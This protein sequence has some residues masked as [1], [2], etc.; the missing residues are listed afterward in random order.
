MAFEGTLQD[1]SL[2]DVCR[3]MGTGRK[4]GCLSITDRSSFGYIYFR[5]GRVVHA[6]MLNRP[7]RLGEM[8]VR[9]R[10]VSREDLAGA[11]RGQSQGSSKRLG[12]LLLEQ[13]VIDQETLK[14]YVEQQVEEAVHHLFT[15]VQGTFHFDPGQLPDED[16]TAL[17]D[18][19]V[20]S[21]LTSV[22][23]RTDDFRR[24][25]RD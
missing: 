5:D 2:A 25:G 1:V 22:R 20:E 8:L 15:W 9:N 18:F 17:V 10:I 19:S 13:G 4:T 12:E 21:L 24:E 7:D 3:L 16:V 11:V 6:A 14:T 23:E